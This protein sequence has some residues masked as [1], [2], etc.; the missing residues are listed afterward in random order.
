MWLGPHPL[1]HTHTHTHTHTNTHTHM[2]HASMHAR[3]LATSFAPAP[4]PSVVPPPPFRLRPSSRGRFRIQP[5]FFLERRLNLKNPNESSDQSRPFHSE[6]S[7]GD[8]FLFR[9]PWARGRTRPAARQQSRCC[10]PMTPRFRTIRRRPSASASCCDVRFFSVIQ[11]AALQQETWTGMESV[12]GRRGRV[13]AAEK[14]SGQ[15][16]ALPCE[17]T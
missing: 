6:V 12:R 15:A 7:G 10:K 16:R 13:R 2:P 17:G 4:A 3:S 8:D 14:R 5:S 9:P 1:V 11:R